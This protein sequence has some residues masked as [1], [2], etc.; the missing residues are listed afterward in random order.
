VAGVTVATRT[1]FERRAVTAT[2]VVESTER[3]AFQESETGQRTFP[4]FARVRYDVDGTL[5]RSTLTLGS[6]GAG[7]CPLLE[8]RGQRVAVAYDVDR[9]GSARLAGRA[10]G[11]SPFLDPVVL[12]FAGLGLLLLVAAAIN[13]AVEI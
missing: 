8:R 3:G 2:A 1:A 7:A 13:Y 10:V 5:V 11:G 4:V 12:G 9:P 6:C